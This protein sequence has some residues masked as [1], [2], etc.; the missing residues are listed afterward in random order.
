MRKILGRMIGYAV[1]LATIAMIYLAWSTVSTRPSTDV[2]ELHAPVVHVSPTVPGRIISIAVEN[3]ARV[4]KGDVLFRL[5]PQSYQLRLDQAEAELRA[6]ESELAQGQ[7]NIATEQSNA[8]VAQKQIERAQ[9][10]VDLAKQT[11]DRL[12][13]LLSKGFVTAQQVDQSRTAYSDALVSLDQALQ[14]SEGASQVIGTLDTRQAQVDTA[15]ATVA[16]A[17][18]DLDNTTVRAAF[19]GLVVGLTVPVGEF[20][21][22]G[23]TVFS[24]IDTSGW[25]AVAYFRETELP[26]IRIGD[27]ADVFV[28]AEPDRPISGTIVSMGWGIRSEEAVTVLG[29]PVVSSSLNWVK[30][31]KRFPVYVALDDPPA[32]LM[33]VGA[34]A[35]VAIS[36]SA[37]AG[38]GGDHR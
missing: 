32:E 37:A 22:T 1:F 31:A 38:D 3:N 19:D 34:S 36:G 26:A 10:N 24:M 5:D 2:A 29:L 16:L 4:K 12:E 18:R 35:I 21:V 28:M 13:P 25:E 17:R 14:Q 33:R 27:K 9:N 30:V 7:R 23:Q 11:L 15:R 20:V 6:A 8:D